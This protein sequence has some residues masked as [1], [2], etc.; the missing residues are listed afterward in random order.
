MGVSRR[1]LVKTVWILSGA[2]LVGEMI[3]GSLA[4]LWPRTREKEKEN[5][6]VAGHVEDFGIGTILS[7]RREKLFIVRLDQGFLAMSSVCTHLRCIVPWVETNNL[8]ECP[9]HA[10]K[11]N[12]VGEVVGGPPPRP[13]DLYELRVLGGK[14]VVDV[15][16]TIQ[17][18]EFSS[19]QV[20]SG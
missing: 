12:W 7:F 8:F 11:F 5:L 14:V 1:K 20:V 13:L 19:L 3:V 6:F 16:K 15:G 17:R 18:K 2:V 4:F 10:G 9:C